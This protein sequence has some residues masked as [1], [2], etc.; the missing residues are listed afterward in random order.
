MSVVSGFVEL[1]GLPVWIDNPVLAH[2]AERILGELLASIPIDAV[3]RD[4]FHGEV[5]GAIDVHAS[6]LL[7]ARLRQEHHVGTPRAIGG[8]KPHQNPFDEDFTEPMLFD[9]KTEQS[10]Q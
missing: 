4:D 3:W 8:M 9:V 10:C 1:G 7:R 5:G 6:E 2:A